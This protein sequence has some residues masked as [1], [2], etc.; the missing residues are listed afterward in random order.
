MHRGG[1]S[2]DSRSGIQGEAPRFWDLRIPYVNAVHKGRGL[3]YPIKFWN[4]WSARGVY[5]LLRLSLEVL[6]DPMV[7][8]A[9]FGGLVVGGALFAILKNTGSKS[10]ESKYTKLDI[11]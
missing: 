1:S 5:P 7:I 8:I 9:L 3:R 11:G 6:L 4:F 2:L 10:A